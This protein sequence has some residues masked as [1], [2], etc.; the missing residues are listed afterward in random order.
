MNANSRKQGTSFIVWS[1]AWASALIAIAFF[2]KGHPAKLWLETAIF[3][4][5]LAIFTLRLPRSAYVR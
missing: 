4:G 1:L 5:A 3:G 2:F